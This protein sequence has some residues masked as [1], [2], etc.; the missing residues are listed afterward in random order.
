[1]LDKSE[2]VARLAAHVAIAM[3]AGPDEGVKLA[4][5][6][7][8]LSKCDLLTEVVGEFPELQGTMGRGV[9]AARDGEPDAVATR[10][11]QTSIS[12]A[13]PGDALPETS[14]TGCAPRR[15]RTRL[16]TLVG[17][18]GIGLAPSGDRDPYALR[19]SASG[20]CGC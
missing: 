4:R 3:G 14:R 20:C 9:R 2:R 12:R 13:L 15:S 11:R 5:R 8:Q 7:G 10:A 19:R 18:F 16:D 6:A 17:I 1:M